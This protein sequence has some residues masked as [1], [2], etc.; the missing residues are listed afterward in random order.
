MN[1]PRLR[2]Q[3]FSNLH[4]KLIF[5]L[6]AIALAVYLFYIPNPWQ[7]HESPATGL[8]FTGVLLMFGGILGRIFSTLSIG[9]LKDRIIVQTELYSV[10]RNPLYFSSFLMAAGTGLLFARLDFTILVVAAFMGIF[11]PMMRNEAR[12]LREKFPEYAD[13]ERRVPLFFPNFLLWQEREQYQINFRLLKRTLFDAS[14]ILL[15]IPVMLFLRVW[16]GGS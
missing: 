6:L 3:G 1:S 13:Y 15:A 5:R 10:C 12:F 11:L 2:A 9:G 8:R 7:L 16:A 4:R 14:L